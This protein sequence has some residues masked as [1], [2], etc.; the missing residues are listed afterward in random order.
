MGRKVNQMIIVFTA[1]L[2][3][4]VIMIVTIIK[5][6]YTD[7]RREIYFR[8][9]SK[10][11]L[12]Y[13][14]GYL[15]SEY[16][17]H[18]TEKVIDKTENYELI[19]IIQRDKHNGLRH[20]ALLKSMTGIPD[21]KFLV[22]SDSMSLQADDRKNWLTSIVNIKLLNNFLKD[23]NIDERDRIIESFLLLVS[24]FGELQYSPIKNENSLNDFFYNNEDYG[25]LNVHH[26]KEFSVDFENNIYYEFLKWGVFEIGIKV[27]NGQ[28]K[29]LFDKNIFL[30][31]TL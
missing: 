3:L 13:F 1:L 26:E 2:G 28:I 20:Y 8:H 9:H 29:Y 10:L 7:L 12:G 27:E 18:Y 25:F 17:Q 11:S 19:S 5:G 4:F 24:G 21:T 6:D 16:H 31:A 23:K 30:F 15:P 22:D 14:L